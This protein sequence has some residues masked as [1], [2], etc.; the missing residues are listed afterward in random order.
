MKKLLFILVVFLLIAVTFGGAQEYGQVRVGPVANRPACAVGLRIM[1]FCTDAG[2]QRWT[3]CNGTSWSDVSPGLDSGVMP[4]TYV[5]IG[6]VPSY[7]RV[8]GSNATTTGQSLV[9]I[10]GL[11]AALTTNAVYEF[12]ASLTVS[13]TGTF[14]GCTYSVGGDIREGAQ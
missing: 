1:W 2:T 10:T 6:S 4:A 7:A 8:T 14:T 5:P 12:E 3:Y 9:N 11:T 13:T